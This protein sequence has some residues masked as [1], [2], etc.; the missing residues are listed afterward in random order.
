MELACGVYSL[1]VISLELSCVLIDL[2]H[3][4]EVCVE[5]PGTGSGTR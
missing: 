1:F 3:A 2:F 5:A 4:V